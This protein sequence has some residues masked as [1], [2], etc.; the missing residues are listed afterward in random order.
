[1]IKSDQK[2]RSL[3]QQYEDGLSQLNISQYLNMNYTNTK[4]VLQ[5]MPDTYIDRWV[6]RTERG[7]GKW[8]AIWCIVTPPPDCPQPTGVAYDE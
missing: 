8:S 3:L 2:I 5:N 6:E 1:M 7:R 4:Q